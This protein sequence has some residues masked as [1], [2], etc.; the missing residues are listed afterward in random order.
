MR[1]PDAQD[2][3]V[4]DRAKRG[5]TSGAADVDERSGEGE[6]PVWLPPDHAEDSAGLSKRVAKGLTWT[7]IDN[8]GAQLLGLVILVVLLRLVDAKD[9]G[10]V[11]LAAAIV[12]VAQLF[13]D[14]GLGDALVQRPSLTRGHIDTAFWTAVLTGS[15]LTGLG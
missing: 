4:P 7:L 3:R 6:R 13:V 12:G 5:A 10:L 9:V 15:L 8:W 2:E 11:A 1:E 14:Q